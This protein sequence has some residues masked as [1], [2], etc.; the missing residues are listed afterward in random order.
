MTTISDRAARIQA[1]RPMAPYIEA[2]FERAGEGWDPDHN[3]DGYIGLC[4]AENKLVWDLLEPKLTAARTLE[5]AAAAYDTM[6]GSARFRAQLAAFLRARVLGRPVEPDQ[7]AVLNGAGSV[8]E[9]LF[10]TLCDPGDAVLVPTPS[11]SGFWADL[12]TRDEV[13]ITEVPRD[14]RDGFALSPALLDAALAGSD[15]PVKALLYTNPDNPTGRVAPVEE[16][17]AVLAWARARGLHVV[18]DELYSLCGFRG[19]P[20][21]SGA[22]RVD[23]LGERIH[24]VWS[25]SKDLAMSGVRTG[26]LVTGNREVLDVVGALALW[27]AVPGTTQALLGDLIADDAWVGRFVAATR[28]R[29]GAAYAQVAAALDEHGLPYVPAEAGF[30]LLLDLRALLEEPSWDAEERLW[31]ALLEERN[32]NLT[33]GAACRAPEPGFF[34]LVFSCVSSD[35]AVEGVRRLTAHARGTAAA[36]GR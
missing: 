10:Y 5:P 34:R 11:Y 18:L 14:V 17:D 26:V 27:A 24:V 19:R 23:E 15:R 12:G 7:L 16:V 35:A 4:V 3:P 22:S 20:F 9:L 28:R 25:F 32:V 30:F 13:V 29:L 1:N 36:R 31:R 33:P 6:S 21:V 2:Q 8:L